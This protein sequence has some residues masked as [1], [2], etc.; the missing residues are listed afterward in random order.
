MTDLITTIAAYLS[1]NF[2]EL[3]PTLTWELAAGRFVAG[4]RTEYGQL[5]CQADINGYCAT[6]ISGD[7][8]DQRAS[9]KAHREMCCEIHFHVFG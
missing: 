4:T 8:D 5:S 2:P 7:R 9:C 1:K 6:V 3:V